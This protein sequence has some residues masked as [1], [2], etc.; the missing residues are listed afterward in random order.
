MYATHK[1]KFE[2]AYPENPQLGRNVCQMVTNG[3]YTIHRLNKRVLADADLIEEYEGDHYM[4]TIETYENRHNYDL[5]NIK[6]GNL[7][8]LTKVIVDVAQGLAPVPFI[9]CLKIS[10]IRTCRKYLVAATFSL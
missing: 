2:K 7:R 1:K 9:K 4:F 3:L 8:L 10:T 6:L 5:K